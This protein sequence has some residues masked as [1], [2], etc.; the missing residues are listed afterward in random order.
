MTSEHDVDDRPISLLLY[1][2]VL[3]KRRWLIA[4]GTAAL[5][6]LA[7]A[8]TK[9]AMTPRFA[10]QVKFLPSKASDMSARMSTI[11]GEGMQLSA[12]SAGSAD[13][14]TAL[15]QSPLFLQRIVQKPV[16]I[17]KLGGVRPLIAYFELGTDA[18]PVRVKK[19]IEALARAIKVTPGKATAGAPPI[20]TIAVTTSE[21]Q[22]SADIANAFLDELVVYN[23]SVRNAKA[24]QNRVFIEKQLKDT[25]GLLTDAEE[26]VANFAAHNR[27]LA[28][29][30]LEAQKDRLA[31]ALKV[32]EEVFVTLKKQLELARI[33]EQEN[34][35][36]IEI[37]E[38][39]V[40]PLHKSGPSTRNNALLAGVV[41]LMLLSGLVIA[42]DFVKKLDP[43]DAA[44]RE[45]LA[46]LQDI[47][48]D[49]TIARRAFRIAEAG[50]LTVP[51][52]A[53]PGDTPVHHG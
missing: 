28:T 11:V 26:D 31:R 50:K 18:E 43:E 2:N 53:S 12:E 24:I 41:G 23:Q 3:L 38:R 51:D 19:G 52:R 44:A 21:P 39:A 6:I 33:E 47:K 35:P 5:V 13:Y 49:L 37:V 45:F 7:G 10:A 22:L 8:Y 42:G 27:K 25:Q 14:Y 32:Q 34:Q 30:D 20:I 40:P 48:G 9:L 46:I 1:V 16:T 17:Q 36:S 29:P 4:S 15:L